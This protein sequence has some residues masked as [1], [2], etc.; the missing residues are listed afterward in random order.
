MMEIWEGKEEV[1]GRIFK[2]K[3]NTNW[4]RHIWTG[5]VWEIMLESSSDTRY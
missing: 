1:E 3:E 5:G 4:L 2:R